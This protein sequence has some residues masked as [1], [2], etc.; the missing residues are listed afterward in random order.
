MARILRYTLAGMLGAVIAW[1]IMEPTPLMPNGEK[2]VSYPVIFVIGLIFGLIVGLLMGLAE[3]VGLSRRDAG[4]S[5]L[6][7]A[8][9]GAIGGVLGLTFGNT[10]YNIMWTLAGAGSVGA[11]HLPSNVPADAKL[12][13][14]STPGI[15]SF[16]LLLIGRGFGW[17]LIGGFVGLSQ[18]VATSSTRKMTN[19][20]I[21]GLIG[22]GIGGSVFE[23]LKWANLSG[24]IAFPPGMIRFISFAIT[25]AAIGLFIGFI[26]EV[27]KKAWLMRL[28][29]RK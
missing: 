2:S 3:G 22:G 13:S 12:A 26:E 17:A 6:A 15:I 18:G 20:A 14:E 4:R 11:A 1:A 23:M 10:F 9:G 28:V 25:G 29:G 7:G 8:V 5:V 19:G 16:L 27:T 24:T 21:G